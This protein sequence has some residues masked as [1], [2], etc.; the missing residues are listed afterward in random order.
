MTLSCQDNRSVTGDR[1]PWIL[2]EANTHE[3]FLPVHRS[4]CS[5]HT[6]QVLQYVIGSSMATP[7][8][9]PSLSRSREHVL[10]PH[11]L[12]VKLKL[13]LVIVPHILKVPS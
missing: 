12:A 7:P 2:Q 9:P 8:T 5:F 6:A 4:N 13:V 11:S 3:D 1:R 10:V